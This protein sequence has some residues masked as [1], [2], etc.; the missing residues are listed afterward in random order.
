VLATVAVNC[1]EPPDETVAEVGATVT[2]IGGGAD[3]WTVTFFE[4]D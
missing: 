3:G 4:V 1:R 2:E